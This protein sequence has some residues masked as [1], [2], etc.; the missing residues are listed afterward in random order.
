MDDNFPAYQQ[1]QNLYYFTK[2]INPKTLSNI[3]PQTR[4][5]S[6]LPCDII[7]TIYDGLDGVHGENLMNAITQPQTRLTRYHTTA[8]TF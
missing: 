6:N 7:P 1:H 4:D 5:P 3:N 2:Q 8:N